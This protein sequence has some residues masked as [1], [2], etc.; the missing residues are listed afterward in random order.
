MQARP[1]ATRL[2]SEEEGIQVAR[3]G[4]FERPTSGSGDQRS[5]QLSYGRAVGAP[6]Y[7]DRVIE[8]VRNV[9]TVHQTFHILSRLI[10][11]RQHAFFRSLSF[12][13]Q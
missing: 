8:G 2:Y 3:P 6:S 12:A 13:K 1:P 5:I 4:R 10:C 11:S 7:R 9:Q